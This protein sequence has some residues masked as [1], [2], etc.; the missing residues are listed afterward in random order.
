[1]NITEE[2]QISDS[3]KWKLLE[4]FK[5]F[6][7]ETSLAKKHLKGIEKNT[8]EEI[9]SVFDEFKKAIYSKTRH[10]DAELDLKIDKL[11]TEVNKRIKALEDQL[12]PIR[13]WVASV[14]WFF[15]IIFTAVIVGLIGF[16]GKKLG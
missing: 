8:R 4:L 7:N 10:R 11:E 12:Q 9:N 2:Q 3:Q 16:M 5:E 1:M 13:F 14:K 15:G 6:F